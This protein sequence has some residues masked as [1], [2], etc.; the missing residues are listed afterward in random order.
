MQNVK[1]NLIVKIQEM[2]MKKTHADEKILSK[3]NHYNGSAQHLQGA[4]LMEQLNGKT[5]R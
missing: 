1:R 4:L 5:H 2:E 3:N